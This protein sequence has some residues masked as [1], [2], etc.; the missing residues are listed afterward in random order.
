MLVCEDIE[1]FIAETSPRF[2][3]LDNHLL[4]SLSPMLGGFMSWDSPSYESCENTFG[5]LHQV[6]EHPDR[7]PPKLLVDFSRLDAATPAMF[8]AAHTY[9]SQNLPALRA[10]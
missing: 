7:H 6:L 8:T 5:M 2:L 4:F 3:L 10:L 9:L 1:V